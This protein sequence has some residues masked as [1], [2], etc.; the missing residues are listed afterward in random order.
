MHPAARRLTH[1]DHRGRGACRK[2]RSRPQW[3][4][5]LAQAAGLCLGNQ[6]AELISHGAGSSSQVTPAIPL[7]RMAWRS[8]TIA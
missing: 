3:Q 6:A 4:L 7:S 2:D 1:Q 5:R 8:A